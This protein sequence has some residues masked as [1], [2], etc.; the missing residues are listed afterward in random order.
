ME[1]LAAETLPEGFGYEWTTLAFQ[2]IRAGNTA[3]FAFALGGG[4]R[5]PGAGGAI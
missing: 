2:Q 3:V 4:V 1:K 5:V